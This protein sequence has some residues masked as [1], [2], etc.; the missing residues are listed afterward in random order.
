VLKIR[1]STHYS[2][3]IRKQSEGKAK[4][5]VL[6]AI[7]NNFASIAFAVIKNNKL[8]DKNHPFSFEIL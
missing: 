3:Y 8:F 2:H 5:S 7:R 6:N 4:M 1:L